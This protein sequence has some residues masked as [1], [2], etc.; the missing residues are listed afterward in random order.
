MLVVEPGKVTLDGLEITSCLAISSV[1]QNDKTYT[2]NSSSWQV[3]DDE[4]SDWE[5]LPDSDVVGQLCPHDPTDDR[6]YRLIGAFVID[7]LVGYHSS[8]VM[9]RAPESS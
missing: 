9:K 3:R 7:E 1:I 8:N 4:D 6:E 2:V 5:A